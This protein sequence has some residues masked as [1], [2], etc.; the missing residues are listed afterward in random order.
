MQAPAPWANLKDHP[1]PIAGKR[2]DLESLV[3]GSG[4]P[5]R[6]MTKL[7]LREYRR[8]R[9]LAAVGDMKLFRQR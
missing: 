3:T 6:K 9:S 8:S 1:L 4:G 2:K 5:G 7:V